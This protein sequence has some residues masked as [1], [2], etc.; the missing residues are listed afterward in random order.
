MERTP[1]TPRAAG[2]SVGRGGDL[3]PVGRGESCGAAYTLG[4]CI[5]A[6][7]P[8]LTQVLEQIMARDMSENQVFYNLTLAEAHC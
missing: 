7:V 6:A 2:R 1:A 3:R 5:A 8:L 4:G